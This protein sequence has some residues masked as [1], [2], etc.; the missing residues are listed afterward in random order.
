[1]RAKMMWIGFVCLLVSVAHGGPNTITYQGSVIDSAAQ[2]VADG[3]YPMRFTIFNTPTGTGSLW[4]EVENTVAVRNSLFSVTLGDGSPFCALFPNNPDLWLEVAI[5]LNRENGF[6]PSE[7]YTPRQKLSAA[8]W[9]MTANNADTLDGYHAANFV[10]GVYAGTGLVRSGSAASPM[11]SADTSYLQVRVTGVA[12]AGRYIRQIYGDGSV[13]TALDLVATNTITGVTAGTGLTGGGTTGAVTL[14]ADTAYLQRRVTGTA[15]VGQFIRAVNADGSVLTSAAITTVIAGTGL[16]GG[17]TSGSIT[18]AADTAYLQHRVTDAAPAGQYIR[19]IN[20][21]G[22][23]VTGVDQT[24]SGSALGWSLTGNAGTSP[25]LNFLG[26]SDNVPIEIRVNNARALRIE[27]TIIPNLVGG[28][29]A[30]SVTSGVIGATICGGG[31]GP[32]PNTVTADQGT[33][34]GGS[35]NIA[36]GGVYLYTTPTLATGSYLAAG[37]GSWASVSDRNI[38]ENLAPVDGRAVLE[39]LSSV[40]V[41]TWNYKTE[42]PSIRH[43]GPM[44]QDLYAAFG[45]GD[46][47]K[48]IATVDADGVALAAIQGLHKMAQE[49]DAQIAAQQERI[50]DL[51]TRLAALEK[52]VNRLAE[53]QAAK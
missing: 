52:I 24:T 17:G 37:S 47:E 12:P 1:M 6:E 9:A 38:K 33:V 48:S 34:G 27:P 35:G 21:D 7:I 15:P 46:S 19:Q 14:S 22:T 29:F 4:E 32:A 31:Y 8:A 49:K 51:E 11:L 16:T 25:S 43:I 50:R 42:R 40:P 53:T 26:T 30:N 44:A 3:D 45:L 18:V 2:P 10:L 13:L 41:N 5:D 23:I 20:A 28:L 36:S 39:K